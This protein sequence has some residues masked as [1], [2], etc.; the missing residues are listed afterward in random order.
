[1]KR[2]RAKRPRFP[3]SFLLSGHHWPM[4]ACKVDSSDGEKQEEPLQGA[5][6]RTVFFKTRMDTLVCEARTISVLA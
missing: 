4:A 6:T 3:S 1:M 2:E 5:M